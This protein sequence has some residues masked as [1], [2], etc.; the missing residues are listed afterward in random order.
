VGFRLEIDPAD[1]VNDLWIIS[2]LA[3]WTILFGVLPFAWWR[4][5]QA[6]HLQPF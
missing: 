5:W 4:K 2:G 1:R 3:L 6:S